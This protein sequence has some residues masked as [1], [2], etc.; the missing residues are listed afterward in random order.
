MFASGL[1]QAARHD[2]CLLNYVILNIRIFRFFII[3]Y[4]IFNAACR[5]GRIYLPSNRK[6]SPV[7]VGYLLESNYRRDLKSH[8]I[9]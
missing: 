5:C 8:V 1:I 7:T 3:W 9:A 2:S 4:A 6:G